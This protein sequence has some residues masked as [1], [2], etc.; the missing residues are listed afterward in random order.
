LKAA[1]DEAHM[2][3]RR[4]AS[5]AHGAEGIK[6]AIRAGIDTIEHSSLIDEEGIRMAKERGTWL[7]FDIYNDDYIL[8]KAKDYNIPQEFVEKEKKIG[9]L[10]RENFEKAFRA[11]AKMI[12]GSDAGVYPHGDNGKQFAFMVKY[13]MTPA[14]AIR[15]ATSSAA[16]AINRKD[17]VGTIEAGK[18]A[19]VIAVDAD[20]L[21]DVTVLEKVAFVMKGG[22]VYKQGGKWTRD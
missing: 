14:Q 21:K 3:G 8:G 12:F 16:E 5:H 9:R 18:F 2:A 11:G 10:Q 19:D 22:Q 7:D 4:I 15:A 1:A 17:D 13:G 6:N 20:P